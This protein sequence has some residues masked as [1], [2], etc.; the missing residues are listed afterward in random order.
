[1]FVCIVDDRDG[2]FLCELVAAA[3]SKRGT[4][5]RVSVSAPDAGVYR[6]GGGSGGGVILMCYVM[7]GV[8]MVARD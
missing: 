4:R 8:Q 2:V 1:V 7:V 5:I 3:E 6:S